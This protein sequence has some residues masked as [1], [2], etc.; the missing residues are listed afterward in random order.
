[1]HEEIEK[2]KIQL[3]SGDSEEIYDA[4]ID[5][6]KKCLYTFEPEVKKMLE[7]E[8]E[9]HRRAA[10]MVFGTYWERENFKDKAWEIYKNDPDEVVQVTAFLNWFSYYK[11][12]KDKKVLKTLLNILKEHKNIDIRIEALRG[13]YL[14]YGKDTPSGVNKIINK[15][16]YDEVE[17]NEDIDW[18]EINE[19]FL[20]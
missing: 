2:I 20:L 15:I 7:S 8:D 13:L 4:I 3:N 10:I 18:I 5:I 11:N 14:V 16:Y 19:M 17:L 6:G 1:M 12:T 9:E